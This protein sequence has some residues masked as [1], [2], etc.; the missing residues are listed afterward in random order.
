V[1]YPNWLAKERKWLVEAQLEVLVSALA[2]W[3][4]PNAVKQLLVL[5]SLIG[6]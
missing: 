1:I 3:V 2:Q 6:V 5:E 4:K